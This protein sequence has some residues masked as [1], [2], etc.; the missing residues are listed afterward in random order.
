[1]RRG[2]SDT[3]LEIVAAFE[4]RLVELLTAAQDD[5]GPEEADGRRPAP[6]PHRHTMDV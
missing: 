1:M 5:K 4:P 3:A 6:R 2:V